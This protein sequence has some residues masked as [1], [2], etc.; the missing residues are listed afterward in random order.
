MVLKGQFLERMTTVHSDGLLLEALF[1]EGPKANACLIASPHP[2]F[3]GSMDA[4][5]CAELAWA[6]TRA[7]HST[8][9]FNYRGV[10]ASQGQGHKPRPDAADELRDVHA[11][12][13]HLRAGRPGAVHVVGYSFGAW[14][15][16]HYT[17]L[18]PD[19][20]ETVTLVAP[21][22]RELPFDLDALA[23]TKKSVCILVG[24]LDQY[25]DVAALE[26]LERHSNVTVNRIPEADHFFLRGLAELGRLAAQHVGGAPGGRLV[27]LE[28]GDDPPLEL[29]R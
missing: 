7:G 11:V 24:A 26:P 14:L 18:H 16:N 20:V 1:H 10:G 22:L 2:A 27:E 17:L 8:L 4:P 29:D 23:A 3:G 21:P 28:E 15:A 25:L 5:V 13:T 19:M 12:A 6:I 9:R